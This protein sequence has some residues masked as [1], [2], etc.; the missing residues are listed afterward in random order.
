V[1]GYNVQAAANQHEIV[2]AAE[3]SITSPDFGHLE[4]MVSATQRE[5]AAIGIHQSPGVVLADAGYWHQEQMER[6]IDRGIPVLMP[7]DAGNR[8]P[9]NPRPDWNGGIYAFM[10]RVLS[11]DYGHA[12]YR[13]RKIIIKPV[14]GDTKFNRRFDRFQRR[15]RAAARSEWRLMM[16][17][18]N[19]RKLYRRQLTVAATAA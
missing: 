17:T 4:P 2:L 7:P 16:A 14:F 13:Q 3:V 9:G 6:V 5:L 18:N 19:L 8:N 10:R 12:L 15:G 11:S 1:Q